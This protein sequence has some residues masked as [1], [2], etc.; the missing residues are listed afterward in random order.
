MNNKGIVNIILII[1][2]VVLAGALAYVTLIKKPKVPAVR[3]LQTNNFQD[4][5][6]PAAP[7]QNSPE[8][9]KINTVA[10][11]QKILNNLVN[12]WKSIGVSILPGFPNPSQAFYGYPDV[13]QFIGNNAVIISYQDGFNPLFA[14]L[15]YDAGQQKFSYLDKH[16]SPDFKLTGTLWN[17]WRGQYGDTSFSPQT[18]KFSSSRTGDAVYPSDWKLIAENPFTSN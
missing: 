2:V 5:N 16:G 1:L 10:D 17:E 6:Q 15:R 11:N 7:V 12:N 4:N 3:Q 14:V 13:I 8:A 9:T 18:Y